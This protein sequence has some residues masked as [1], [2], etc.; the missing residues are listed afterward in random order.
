MIPSRNL[1]LTIGLALADVQTLS[2]A[3]AQAQA[4]GVALRVVQA[5]P[6][7]LPPKVQA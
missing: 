6:P 4:P 3:Q 2:Q 7:T 1:N 5:L